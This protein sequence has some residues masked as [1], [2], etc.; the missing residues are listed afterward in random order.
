VP[1]PLLE[2]GPAVA[3]D[4]QLAFTTVYEALNYDLTIDYSCP[5]EVPLEGDDAQW[6]EERLRAARLVK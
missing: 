5:P 1:V 6:A 2:D 4:L 3:L